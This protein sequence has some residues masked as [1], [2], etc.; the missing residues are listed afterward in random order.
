VGQVPAWP[1]L[2]QFRLL[3]QHIPKANPHFGAIDLKVID[4][5]S[6]KR[7]NIQPFNH[8]N[9]NSPNRPLVL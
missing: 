1:R 8:F 5:Q 6:K 9:P 3:E 4:N 2:A 7:L